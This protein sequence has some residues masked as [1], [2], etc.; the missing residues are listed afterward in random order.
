MIIWRIWKV[1]WDRQHSVRG[2]SGLWKRVT[3]VGIC[4]FNEIAAL[5]WL[6][7]ES[8]GNEQQCLSSFFQGGSLLFLTDLLTPQ[9][10]NPTVD[11]SDSS[12][13]IWALYHLS[14]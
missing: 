7:H 1:R 9:D 10:C 11:K 3:V 5:M 2:E 8:V 13:T 6:E 12:I 14:E 4:E